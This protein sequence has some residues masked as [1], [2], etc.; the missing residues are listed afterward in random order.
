MKYILSDCAHLFRVIEEKNGIY[1]MKRIRKDF[2]S[3][4]F[5]EYNPKSDEELKVFRDLPAEL[6]EIVLINVL[7]GYLL[8]NDYPMIMDLL[9]R[10]SKR[11][12]ERIFY[13]IFGFSCRGHMKLVEKLGNTMVVISDIH[14]Y[15]RVRNTHYHS[16]FQ[17]KMSF[18]RLGHYHPWDLTGRL[19]TISELQEL[20]FHSPVYDLDD[21]WNRIVCGRSVA[22]VVW[23]LAT[24]EDGFLNGTK[25]LFPVIVL[26]LVNLSDRN[27]LPLDLEVF[28]CVQNG[29]LGFKLL[30]KLMFG[31]STG[32]YFVIRTPD[33]SSSKYHYL[34]EG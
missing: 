23:I 19:G 21:S 8:N 14:V 20:T 29:W 11:F 32:L 30:L 33:D 34:L 13:W 25:E 12:T 28:E 10:F 18:W 4:P 1:R 5:V 24:Y 7:K 17:I 9:T 6:V 16:N 31:K 3:D 2:K 22:D 26:N 27:E 15:L